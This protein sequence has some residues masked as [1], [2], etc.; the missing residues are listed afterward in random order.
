MASDSLCQKVAHD[1]VAMLAPICPHWAEELFHEA[2]G[3][4]GSVYNEPWPEFDPEQAKANE[5]EIAVQIKGK[6]RGHALVAA[7]ATEDEIAEAGKAAVA[8]QLEGKTIRKVIVVKGRLVNIVA[9]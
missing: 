8:D 5:V 7:D 3:C 2:L 6:V 4:E 1:V 9:V